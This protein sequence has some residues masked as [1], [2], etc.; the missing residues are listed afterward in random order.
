MCCLLYA[1][2]LGP[3]Y[4]AVAG[5]TRTGSFAVTATDVPHF[6]VEVGPDIA[7]RIGPVPTGTTALAGTAA[8]L[9]ESLSFRTPPAEVPASD[10]WMIEG[11]GV[12]FGA[13]AGS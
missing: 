2:A 3:V 4:L 10:R 12:V 7:V 1:A 6:V 9:I 5:S 13:G 8:D 11:L